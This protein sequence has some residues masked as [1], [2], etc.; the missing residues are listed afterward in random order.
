MSFGKF[1]GFM[2]LTQPLETVW[3]NGKK[4]MVFPNGK[5]IDQ[6]TGL[7]I[8]KGTAINEFEDVKVVDVRNVDSRFPLNSLEQIQQPK[9]DNTLLIFGV[10]ALIALVIIVGMFLHKEKK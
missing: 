3:E 6:E 2:G 8:R 7:L 4:V 1:G 10:L 9:T 5:V